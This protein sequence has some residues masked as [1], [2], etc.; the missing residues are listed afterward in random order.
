MRHLRNKP[1]KFANKSVGY[2]SSGRQASI[3]TLDY[4]VSMTGTGLGFDRINSERLGKSIYVLAVTN[5]DDS[6]PWALVANPQWKDYVL[7]VPGA[8]GYVWDENDSD[9]PNLAGG[10]CI[11]SELDQAFVMWDFARNQPV[12][13]NWGYAAESG[14]G[15]YRYGCL[16][17]AGC[18]Q[19]MNLQSKIAQR[20][21]GEKPK[22]IFDTLLLG[23]SMCIKLVTLLAETK[24]AYDAM[25]AQARASV[26]VIATRQLTHQ[27]KMSAVAP[28]PGHKQPRKAIK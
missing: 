12:Q 22:A 17:A 18:L 4:D 16:P 6:A 25:Q 3:V 7:L 24:A 15:E 2:A 8:G 10:V 9:C 23:L 1:V 5:A 11:W 26:Q 14:Y 28:P 19:A 21:R 13:A 27:E 20:M